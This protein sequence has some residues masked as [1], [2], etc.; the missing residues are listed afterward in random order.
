ME[1]QKAKRQLLENFQNNNFETNLRSSNLHATQSVVETLPNGTVFSISYPGYKAG[2]GRNGNIIYDYRVDI[3]KNGTTTALSHTNIIADIYNKIV[4][5]G[6]SADDLKNV[7]IEISQEGSNNI[8]DIVGRLPYTSATPVQTLCDIIRNA[9]GSKTYNNIGNSFDLTVEELLTAIKFIVLQ[10]DINYPIKS[11]YEGRKM[12]FERYLE[13]IFITQN[14]SHTLEEVI[15]RAL[16]H[17]RPPQWTDMD[18]S[19]RNGIR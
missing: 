14:T 5:C 9:H 19:F 13:T 3:V 16:S 1:Y 15:N 10:E 2:V 11:G 4:N 7:L 6:M 12:P 8:Q 17:T 18:Y